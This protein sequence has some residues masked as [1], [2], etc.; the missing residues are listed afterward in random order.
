MKACLGFT[1]C[2][3][4]I[5]SVKKGERYGQEKGSSNGQGREEAQPSEEADDRAAFKYP[6]GEQESVING[7]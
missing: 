1:E 3:L 2:K 7:R 4:P 5:T 6:E